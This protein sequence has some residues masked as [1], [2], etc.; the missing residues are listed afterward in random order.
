M[1]VFLS[2]QVTKPISIQDLPHDWNTGIVMYRCIEKECVS[3]GREIRFQHFSPQLLLLIALYDAMGVSNLLPYNVDPDC[4]PKSLLLKDNIQANNS[5]AK[6]MTC[7]SQR[8]KERE[9]TK[10]QHL[11]CSVYNS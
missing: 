8:K 1:W 5:Q 9:L 4:L 3:M 7:L 6:Y 10:K 2:V 11:G